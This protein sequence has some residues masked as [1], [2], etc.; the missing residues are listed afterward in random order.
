MRHAK[1]SALAQVRPAYLLSMIPLMA[2]VG[3]GALLMAGAGAA[4]ANDACNTAGATLT[5]AGDQAD[6]IEFLETAPFDTLVVQAL[7]GDIAPPAASGIKVD[8]EQAFDVN[9]DTGA[10]AI[11]ATGEGAAGIHLSNYGSGNVSLTLSGDVNSDDGAGISVVTPGNAS[12]VATGNVTAR[13]DAIF[14]KSDTSGSATID[15]TGTVISHEGAGVIATGSNAVSIK[16]RGVIS[17]QGDAINAKSYGDN[18]SFVLVDHAGGAITSYE[19]YGIY[20]LS[21]FDATTVTVVGDISSFADGIY[22]KAAGSSA[23]DSAIVWST[24]KIFSEDG[25]GIRALSAFGKAEV[26][27]LGNIEA[28]YDGIY[29]K[30][31]GS[32]LASIDSKGA[33]FSD[34]GNGLVAI[35]GNGK[36]SVL[37]DGA[38]TAEL[39]AIRVKGNG[40]VDVDSLGVVSSWSGRGIDAESGNGSA[41]VKSRGAVQ[42]KLEAVSIRSGSGNSG[43]IVSLDSE[44]ALTSWANRGIDVEAANQAIS[45]LS[46]GNIEAALEGIYAKTGGT[47]SGIEIDSTGTITSWNDRGIHAEAA[48]GSVLINNDGAINAKKDGIYAKSTGNSGSYQVEVINTGAIRSW[49]NAGIFATASA[50]AV[51]VDNSGR[52]DAKTDGIRAVSTGAGVTVTQVGDIAIYD[53]AGIHAESTSATVDVEMDGNITGGAYGIYGKNQ[54]T[55]V[56]VKLTEGHTISA[57]N[58]AGVYL[59]GITTTQFDNYGTVDALAGNVAQTGGWAT[60][61]INN[62]GTMIGNFDL[63]VGHSLLNNMAG[64]TMTVGNTVKLDAAGIFTNAGGVS[65]G[66]AGE[67][68]TTA[69]TGNFVQSSGGRLVMDVDFGTNGSDLLTVSGSAA[70]DGKVGLV[71]SDI[72]AVVPMTFTLLTADEITIGNLLIANQVIDGDIAYIG[73]TDVQVTVNG[74]DFRTEGQSQRNSSVA[75]ALSSQFEQGAPGLAAIFTALANVQE[76]DEYEQALA[77]L[78][79]EVYAEATGSTPAAIPG[80]A[81]RMLS[82]RVSDGAYAFNAEGECIWF[83]TGMTRLDRTET[84]ES[85]GYRQT[86][87]NVAA[88]GQMALSPEIRLGGAV[89]LVQSGGNNSAS[90]QSRSDRLQGGVVVK[91]D[92]EAMLL[93]ASLTA[94]AGSTRTTRVV[95]I[96]Q[97]NETLEGESQN[98]FVSGRLHAAYTFAINNAYIRPLADLD[99]TATYFGALTEAGGVSALEI[100]EGSQLIASLAPA[101]EIGS[102]F[103]VGEGAVA[104][105]YLRAGVGITTDQALEMTA[106]FVEGNGESFSLVSA[107][108]ALT[109][110]LSAGVDL[111]S[112]NNASLRVFY[113]A[114]FG[115]TTTQ[116]GIG[117]KAGGSF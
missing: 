57:T 42:A 23:S 15:H 8:V 94:G 110:K 91:Y 11:D 85:L 62:Y 5:C 55:D 98:A 47:S 99:V 88:G 33:I 35:S 73:G 115:A 31:D 17:A 82:C 84:P 37:S 63:S 111:V 108:D 105:P 100:D 106:R 95:S 48:R 24:G 101:M 90:G 86:A 12:S 46:I 56:K 3:L 1:A 40:D 39:T 45:V 52:I 19:G 25:Y 72:Y 83:S 54:S 28:L 7:T 20:A 60:N 81:D 36:A 58:T 4:R 18:G 97:L 30:A 102:Q 113:E 71:I 67:V 96:G 78:T 69:L 41:T 65:L 61:T 76:D 53:G 112:S 64:A 109:G 49:D 114:S 89:G 43:H 6:G 116:H 26:T 27:S 93:A 2:S 22:A 32:Q 44:G 74:I 80:F 51:S 79:P 107:A 70:L 13:T 50:L 59:S 87:L 34:E 104:R 38:V 9:I 77:Q 16:T 14:V 10:F 92:K 75:G 68:Y 21:A 66:G 117:M 103:D 29:A